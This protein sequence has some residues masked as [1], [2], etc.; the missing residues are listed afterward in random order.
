MGDTQFAAVQ[1]YAEGDNPLM[2]AG[3][4]MPNDNITKVLWW[5]TRQHTGPLVIHGREGS[6]GH[7]FTQ[8]IGLGVG[9]GLYP[10]QTVQRRL[11]DAHRDHRRR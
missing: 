9:Q 8:S 10:S 5:V 4:Q 11:L 2:Y 1:F 6:S 7:A 3:G